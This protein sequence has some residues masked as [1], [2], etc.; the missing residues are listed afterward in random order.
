MRKRF[1]LRRSSP[2]SWRLGRPRVAPLGESGEDRRSPKA[3]RAR[4]PVD[5][6]GIGR[7]FTSDFPT[8]MRTSVTRAG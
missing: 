5:S 1:G 7:D 2:L 8:L 3:L 4:F 6:L